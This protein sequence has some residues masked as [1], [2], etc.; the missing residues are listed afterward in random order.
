MGQNH[1]EIRGRQQG[2]RQQQQRQQQRTHKSNRYA[3]FVNLVSSVGE[4]SRSGLMQ[5]KVQLNVKKQPLTAEQNLANAEKYV[6]KNSMR[7]KIFPMR[8]KHNSL[9]LKAL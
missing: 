5:E 4:A 3:M 7:K 2:Q 9:P 6:V 1:Y 8:K